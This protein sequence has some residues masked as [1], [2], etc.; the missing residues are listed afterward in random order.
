M[1]GRTNTIVRW[2]VKIGVSGALMAFLLHKIPTHEIVD[3]A[4]RADRGLL[5]AATLLFLVSNVAGWFQWHALLRSSGVSVDE[6]GTFRFYFIGLFFNNFLPANI[7]G[8][9]VKVYDMTREGESAYRVIAVTLLDRVLGVFSLCLLAVIAEL[10]LVGRTGGMHHALYL[11]VFIACMIPALGFYFFRPLGNW[12]RRSVLRMR[13]LSLDARITAIID[14]LSPFRG[15]RG[16]LMRL[17]L[18]SVLIQAMR[19]FTH[20][21]VAMAVGVPI[22]PLLVAQF[23]VFIPLLSLAMIPPIT[24]NGLGIREGLGILLFAEAGILA[25]DAFVIEFG[26][27][28]ISVAV[29]LLGFAFFLARR[30]GRPSS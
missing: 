23:F 4:R 11:G 9:A 3:L 20:V 26:T 5:L 6:A 2:A 18:F 27:Y 22:T 17:V 24:I 29:S 21:L 12:L 13:A 19:V 28:L 7:G 16:L 30:A 14:H 10:L 8:D 15:R 1:R 25:A